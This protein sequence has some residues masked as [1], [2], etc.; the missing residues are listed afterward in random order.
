MRSRYAAYALGLTAY[1]VA[2]TDPDGPAW[3]GHAG[4]EVWRASIQRFSRA[5]RF[6]GLDILDAPTPHGATGTVTF[7]ARLLQAGADATFAERSAF[8]HRGGNWRYH[9]GERVPDAAHAR[10]PADTEPR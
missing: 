9:R 3:E 10:S 6:C 8:V 5:T 1:I 7:R 2:T 4:D